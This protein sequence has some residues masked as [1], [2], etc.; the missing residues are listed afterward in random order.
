MH[1]RGVL[2]DLFMQIS[3]EVN[4]PR[5]NSKGCL[6]GAIKTD[7]KCTLI[8]Q[9]HVTFRTRLIKK[10]NMPFKLKEGTNDVF[11]YCLW[12]VTVFLLLDLKTK[13]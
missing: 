5:A 1:H 8:K 10:V 2:H 7:M 11:V 6:I 13:L 12:L 4:T 9:C 3:Q